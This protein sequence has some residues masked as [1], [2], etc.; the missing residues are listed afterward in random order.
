MSLSIDDS[1]RKTGVPVS[2]SEYLVEDAWAH[3]ENG[4]EEVYLQRVASALKSEAKDMDVIVLAQ[5]SMAG[6]KD[7]ISDLSV[8]MLSSPRLGVIA[9]INSYHDLG[10]SQLTEPKIG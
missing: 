10:S 9:A 6:A 1:A 4:R 8:P 5:A 2:I 3:F 7:Y